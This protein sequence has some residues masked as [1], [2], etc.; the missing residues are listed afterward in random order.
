M[1]LRFF[2]CFDGS[3]CLKGNC[4]LK[5][6]LYSEWAE[7]VRLNVFSPDCYSLAILE[8]GHSR[9]LARSP[10]KMLYIEKLKKENL[11]I[12]MFR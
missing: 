1:N 11:P 8:F 3:L 5:A 2:L 4:F 12:S 10:L 7:K 9:P 6:P